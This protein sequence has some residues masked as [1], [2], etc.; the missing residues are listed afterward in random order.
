MGAISKEAFI[1]GGR[2]FLLLLASGL[3]LVAFSEGV[4][5]ILAWVLA[6]YSG[7]TPSSDSVDAIV[8]VG[9]SNTEGFGVRPYPDQ[10]REL[11]EQAG[12]PRPVFNLGVSGFR[13][14]QIAD[15]IEEALKNGR[16]G[17]V[18]FL[19]GVNDL[20]PHVDILLWARENLSMP[21]R[22]RAA[23]RGLRTYRVLRSLV[24]R[25][26]RRPQ[27]A[28]RPY[29]REGIS[30]EKDA[31]VRGERNGPKAAY[32]E[33]VRL[34]TLGEARAAEEAFDGLLRNPSLGPLVEQHQI[35]LI[36]WELA[37]LQ[38]RRFAPLSPDG[39]GLFERSYVD[40]T[41]GYTAL[42]EGRYEEARAIFDSVPR[43]SYW[44]GY[45]W[46]HR[47]W[48]SLL[49]RDFPR[50]DREL[51]EVLEFLLSLPPHL[52]IAHAL[53]GAA[54]AHVLRDRETQLGRWLE[55]HDRLWS[56]VENAPFDPYAREIMVAVRWIDARKRGSRREIE[57]AEY[58]VS[59]RFPDGPRSTLLRFLCENPRVEF[60]DIRQGAP[61]G[62]PRA[63]YFRTP[64]AG[65]FLRRL[66]R[67]EFEEF[68]GPNLERLAA[69]ARTKGFRLI[70]L[71]YLDP[72]IE[73][74][75]ERLRRFA[76]EKGLCLVDFQSMYGAELVADDGKRYFIGD[77]H[78]PNEAGY[79]LVAKGVFDAIR[80]PE[81]RP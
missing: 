31:E 53:A 10:L 6:R 72:K 48:I 64:N 5:A 65:N 27:D 52:T 45:V 38:G 61:I 67:P 58:L 69:L 46:L 2:R 80:N 79:A 35:P 25:L 57:G 66:T 8:C 37:L 1:R 54:L 28:E 41:R 13:T 73:V 43:E 26:A 49:D 81:G 4:L 3:L 76:R 55:A 77:R 71:T 59:E 62:P 11:L 9:D 30:S 75:N 20:R 16:A 15:R 63:S 29:Y 40:F 32:E 23:F 17:T 74:V 44:G 34:W 7:V 22:V 51:S 56:F 60:D 39:L 33:F 70:V 50:A 18:V 68:I 47:A 14:H 24:L 21:E 42:L 12:D 36:R 78:H 19:G